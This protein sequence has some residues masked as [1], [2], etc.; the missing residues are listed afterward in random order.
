[1]RCTFCI[2]IDTKKERGKKSSNFKPVVLNLWVITPKG[3][4]W[5]FKRGNI[6]FQNEKEVA[7]RNISGQRCH[8]LL[9]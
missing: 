5:H 9:L 3:L 6:N 8:A 4:I 2:C 1:M 7:G